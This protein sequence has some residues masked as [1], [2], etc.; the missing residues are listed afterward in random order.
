MQNYDLG[1]SWAI[2]VPLTEIKSF[3]GYKYYQT[4]IV[5]QPKK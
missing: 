5:K 3:L 2:E 4:N 1:S